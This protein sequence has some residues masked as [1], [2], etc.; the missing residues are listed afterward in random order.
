MFLV[1]V[2]Q[3]REEQQA[4][5]DVLVRIREVLADE[6]VIEAELVRQHDDLA[7]FLQRLRPVAVERMHRHR[8]IA[9]PHRGVSRWPEIAPGLYTSFRGCVVQRASAR[10]SSSSI[11]RAWI[12][13]AS[14][15]MWISPSIA[16]PFRF[17]CCA[18]SMT[19]SSRKVAMVPSCRSFDIA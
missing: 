13:A 6:G 11:R 17:F 10:T 14:A 18:S 7:V 5:G 4:V 1:C 2:D 19:L 15:E 8:E 3:R 16:P 12:C 9:K